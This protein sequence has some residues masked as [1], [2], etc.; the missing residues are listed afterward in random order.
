MSK[1]SPNLIREVNMKDQVTYWLTFRESNQKS[2]FE[3]FKVSQSNTYA[4][5]IIQFIVFGFI[6]LTKWFA[7]LHFP[8][9]LTHV[10]FVIGMICPCLHGTF[11]LI[12]RFMDNANYRKCFS[13]ATMNQ[14]II[15]MESFWILGNNISYSLSIIVLVNGGQCGT[16]E[17]FHSFG[18]NIDD[19]QLPLGMAL[20]S[21]M[22]P[23]MYSMI[24]KGAKWEYVT[25]TFVLNLIA[26][27]FC[28]FQY[29]LT[30]SLP[31][32]LIFVP[33]CMVMMY[34]NQRQSIAV[35]LLTQSQQN[36]LEENERLADETHANEMRHMIGNVAHD[37]K[38][39]SV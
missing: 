36:L 8:S 35:F 21:L 4:I 18:C 30:L 24:L 19:R 23:G 9:V 1:I 7:M 14:I 29:N 11:L 2:K 16:T 27:L 6:F 32:V 12:F 20:V 25:L 17:F 33:F 37:L 26:L 34:E 3:E 10:S 38:T 22:L 5:A 31:S 28:V 39:V 13:K 15:Y